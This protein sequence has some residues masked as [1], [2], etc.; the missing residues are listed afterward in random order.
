MTP[1]LLQYNF[2]KEDY[3]AYYNYSLWSSGTLKKRRRND[4]LKTA[5]N[6]IIY[7]ILFYYFLGRTIPIK[8]M[9]PLFILIIGVSLLPYIGYKN[10]LDKNL[11]DFLE[12]A[13][14]AN[15]FTKTSLQASMQELVIKNEFEETI[16]QWK[17]IIKKIE[18]D[19]HY[20]LYTNS[21]QA[22]IIPKNAFINKV[23]K[24]AFD[25]ILST[26]LSLDAQLKQDIHN[27]S[28]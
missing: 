19:T 6:I 24:N 27:A 11:E 26:T 15:L 20:F 9:I 1:T 28:K 7:G 5:G 8:F 16:H 14:N 10:K 3:T 22:I 23:E 4:F 21:V 12:D 17:S 25:K 13:D 18:I 2:T